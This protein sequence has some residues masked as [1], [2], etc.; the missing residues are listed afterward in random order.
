MNADGSNIR[1]V[2][3]IGEV[4]AIP[5]WSPD[6]KTLA[7][8]SNAHFNRY[9]VYTIGLDGKG[10]SRKTLSHADVIQPAWTADGKG[11]GFARDG[12]IW[13][14]EGGKETQL[15]SGKDDDSKPAWRPLQ[16]Q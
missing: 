2:T 16:Q 14:V 4:S 15:T 5:A 1:Q 12:A 7:F 8:Q 9:E 6:G 11:I 10:L 3:H 13:V